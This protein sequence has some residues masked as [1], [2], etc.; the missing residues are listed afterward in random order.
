MLAV[1]ICASPL[2][3]GDGEE[4]QGYPVASGVLRSA[5]SESSILAAEGLV[6]IAL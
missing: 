2:R 1:A 5:R 3:R 6:N 4:I